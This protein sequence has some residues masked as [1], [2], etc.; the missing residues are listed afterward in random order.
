MPGRGHRKGKGPGVV[1]VSGKFKQQETGQ[2]TGGWRGLGSE[3]SVLSAS[4]AV[5]LLTLHL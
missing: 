4:A 1:T 3:G 2:S 5:S